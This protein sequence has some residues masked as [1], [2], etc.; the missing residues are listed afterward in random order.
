[1]AIGALAECAAS[2]GKNITEFLNDLMPLFMKGLSDDDEEVKS[3]SAYG[4]GI[5]CNN[6]QTDLSR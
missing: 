1:M 2:L 6:S 5:L 3:N 4:I